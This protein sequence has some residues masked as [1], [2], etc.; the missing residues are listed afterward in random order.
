MRTSAEYIVL[1]VDAPFQIT[2][3]VWTT[4]VESNLV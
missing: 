2:R 4:Y 3:V 1:C